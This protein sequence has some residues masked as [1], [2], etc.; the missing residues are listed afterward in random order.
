MCGRYVLRRI[1]LIRGGFD[2]SLLPGFEEFTERP[3]FNFAPSQDIPV[4]RLD[5]AGKR[6]VGPVR[7]GLIPHWSK[8]LPKVQPINARSES[9]ATS[10]M[11]RD[12]LQR[13]RCI[14][15]TDGFY[16]WKRLDAK[17]KEPT[18]IHFPDERVFGFAGLWERWRD[19]ATD[20]TL[21]TATILTTAANTFMKDIHD[22]MPVILK[23]EDYARWLDRDVAADAVVDLL[24]P[25]PDGELTS[26]PVSTRVN[27]P[28]NDDPACVEPLIG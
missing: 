11:F 27:S 2:A 21:D 5:K 1:D 12:A 4:V 22:R 26:H 25:Y 17:T 23:P 7:W 28:K 13:R 15:P 18:F 3:R 24:R 10:G 8:S 19:P 6:V 20:A 16:E 9:A 14:F